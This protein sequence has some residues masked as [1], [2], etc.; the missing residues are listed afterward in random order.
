MD[1]VAIQPADRVYVITALPVSVPV[2]MP[3]LLPT[4]AITGLL[5]LQTPPEVASASVVVNPIQTVELPVMAGTAELTVT[6]MVA[7]HPPAV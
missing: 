1:F 5:L 3:E 2:T 4:V 6:A 7:E